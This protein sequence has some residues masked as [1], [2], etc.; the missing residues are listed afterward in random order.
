M[1]PFT[2]RFGGSNYSSAEQQQSCCLCNAKLYMV[3]EYTE[4]KIKFFLW[5]TLLGAK[6]LNLHIHVCLT[7]LPF[8][9]VFSKF[10]VL[11]DNLVVNGSEFFGTRWN[12]I[13]HHNNLIF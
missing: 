2:L 6:F 4:K 10:M 11:S 9:R 5:T 3:H 8:V 7:F 12:I 1:L 13:M